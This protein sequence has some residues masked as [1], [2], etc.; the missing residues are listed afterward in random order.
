VASEDAVVQRL[1]DKI[2]EKRKRIVVIG[3][4]LTDVWVH[5]HLKECQD[6][7]RKFVE[8]WRQYTPGGAANAARCLTNWGVDVS[9]YGRTKSDRA[10]KTRFV[11]S[12]GAIVFRWDDEATKL[13][14]SS[15]QWARDCA[16]EMVSFAGAVLLSD[17]DKG[18]MEPT[19][20]REVVSLC[21]RLDIPCVADA[22][23]QP[24]TYAGSILKCNASYQNRYNEALAKKGCLVITYGC[25]SPIV[26]NDDE[27]CGLGYDLHPVQCVNHVGAGDCFAAHLVLALAYGFSLRDSAALAHSAGRVYVQH[28][29]GRPPTLVEIIADCTAIRAL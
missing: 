22:K 12:D 19:F 2:D 24:A 21:S 20:I 4:T 14:C 13:D 26:W 3:D 5:G 6:G 7:C 18:F 17:Y 11:T 16:L 8:M 1:L 29:H 28:S 23:R 27:P 9:L 15:Y 10:T 25:M